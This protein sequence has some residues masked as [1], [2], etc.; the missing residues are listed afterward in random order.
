VTSKADLLHEEEEAWVELR[1]VTDTLTAQQLDEV[2]YYED[3]SGKDLLAHLGSWL[4]EAATILEQL[5]MDT[6]G[7][8]DEDED[9]VNR[10]WL[11][12]WRDVDLG[13]VKAHLHSARGRM[14]QEWELLPPQLAAGKA[15]EWFRDSGVLH[16]REHLP[17]LREWA[18][19]LAGP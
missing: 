1:A 8:W 5:R 10:R 4:A 19:G 3:W 6:Y 13:A 2:G 17:R 14:L 12:V 11:D 15:E 18:A 9:E 7:G 16:Y